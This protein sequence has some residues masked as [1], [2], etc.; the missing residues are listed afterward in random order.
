MP[1]SRPPSEHT[2]LATTDAMVWAQEFVRIFNGASIG[3]GMVDEGTMIAWFANAIETGRSAGMGQVAVAQTNDDGVTVSLV[4]DLDMSRDVRI[5]PQL[6]VQMIDRH[7]RVAQGK[8]FVTYEMA[9]GSL[10]YGEFS[11]VTDLEFFDDRDEEV[12]LVKNTY[13]HL[14]SDDLVLEDPNPIEDDED[15]DEP[16]EVE[17]VTLE[18]S[19]LE[20][21]NE[22]RRD[23]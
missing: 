2:L 19:F 20:G 11:T 1:P 17:D 14:S 16:E 4:T 15:E 23:G 21:F 7:N 6:L 10:I 12:R 18:E 22:G 8:T 5:S 9:D 13:L 3:A